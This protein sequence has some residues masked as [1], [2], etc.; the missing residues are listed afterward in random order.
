MMNDNTA[1][2]NGMYAGNLGTNIACITCDICI[3]DI[4]KTKRMT[5]QETNRIAVAY[6]SWSGNT[7]EV[8]N[9]I[10]KITGS[11]IFEIQRLEDYPTDY[12]A[13]LGIGKK[14][15]RANA[16]PEL[17]DKPRSIDKYGTIFIGYPNWWNTFPAPVATFLSEYDFKGKTIIP[18]CTHGGGGIGH[19]FSDIAKQCSGATV[20]DGFSLNGSA[21]NGNNPEVEKW[22]S[23]ISSLVDMK[24]R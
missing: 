2:K 6:F 23:Q 4:K 10:Q 7:R 1:R 12:N 14:E 22:I 11:D 16:K 20:A 15:I 3:G 13:V 21:V 24:I 8:A 17:K 9:Q 5:I 19:S 18:F